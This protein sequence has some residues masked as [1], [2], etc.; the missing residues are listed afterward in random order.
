L[1]NKD[2]SFETKKTKDFHLTSNTTWP[3]KYKRKVAIDINMLT[4]IYFFNILFSNY[5]LYKSGIMSCLRETGVRAN[6]GKRRVMDNI[7]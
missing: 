7:H 6:L 1:I 3:S 2:N 4:R 5:V